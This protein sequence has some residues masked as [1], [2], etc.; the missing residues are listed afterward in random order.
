[1]PDTT[2]IVSVTGIV[3]SGV[4]GPA[5]T[6]WATRRAQRQQFVRDREARRRDELL[7]L[8]D[9]AAAT[10]GSGATRMRELAEAA[11]AGTDPPAELRAWSETVFSTGQRLRLRLGADHDI[12][13]SYERAR[14]LLVEVGQAGAAGTGQDR[15][16]EAF[17]VARA[18]F[19]GASKKALDAPVSH[20]E[21]KS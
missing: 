6:A 7:G 19:L 18:E 21:L 8:L 16:V 17:E 4:V 3:M 9:E 13:T 12:V 5:A 14:A 15:Q 2:L 20:K 11:D 10:I 1:M